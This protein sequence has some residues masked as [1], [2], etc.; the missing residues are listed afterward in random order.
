MPEF[1]PDQRV[2]VRKDGGTGKRPFENRLG[3]EGTVW[4]ATGRVDGG[5]PLFYFVE[6]DDGTVENINPS[7][8]ELPESG[9]VTT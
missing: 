7:W 1:Q 6:F 8:L 9:V 3:T 5:P 2:R 4:Y